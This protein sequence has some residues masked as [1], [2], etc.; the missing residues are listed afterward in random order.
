MDS[1]QLSE[2]WNGANDGAR[3]ILFLVSTTGCANDIRRHMG[4]AD[5]S[6]AFVLKALTPVLESVGQWTLV[7]AP[8]SRL[9]YAAA[10]AAADG[11]RPIHLALHPMQNIYL[12]PAVPTIVFPF[13]EFPRIPDRDFGF[14][15]RQNWP[16]M[17]RP[18]D[19][20]VTA[21]KFS[22][23]AFRDA[24][25]RCPVEVIP[26]PL[27]PVHFA[28]PD[29]DAD[30]SWTLNCRHF[31]WDERTRETA[32]VPA[33]SRRPNS[34]ASLLRTVP[35][36]V[37]DTYRR[38]I[39]RWLSPEAQQQ[40]QRVKRVVLRQPEPPPPLLPSS[41]LSL[42]GLVYTSI[43]NQS[44]RRKNARDLLSAFLFA[45]RDH[46]DVT[47]V[48][49]LATSTQR[50]FFEIQELGNFYGELGIRHRCRVVVLTDYLTE[51]QM[52]DLLRATT[53]YV[54]S[55]RAEGACLP[56]QQALAAGRP[57]IAPSH[58]A[59]ADY[60]DDEVGFV[61]ESDPE[62]TFWPHDPE[63]RYETSWHR[64]VWSDLRDQF[65]RSATLVEEDYAAYRALARSART[66][67]HAYASH[68]VVAE[69]LKRALAHLPDRSGGE[70]AWVA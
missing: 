25:V 4:S 51:E 20:V 8:E 12:T 29:W 38:K 67:M 45:F 7:S 54:N 28:L 65:L 27:S 5:Y 69:A 61:V 48:L 6:Y 56:L 34:K 23:Q 59:M 1:K 64:I 37:K 19:L 50:E 24:G 21:C 17:C 70:L 55:S 32:E 39:R 13:W 14:D 46:P 31:V 9:A 44:D 18:A 60:I 16:R 35:A 2:C 26:V 33:E 53:Y 22:S 68:E 49:K 58:T 11:Y 36:S 66:R 41:Q 63:H 10:R 15:T 40:I 57:A 47:L 30:F 43:F 3:P 42:S 52:H 62:P